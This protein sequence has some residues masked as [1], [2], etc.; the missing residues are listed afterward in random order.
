MS[1]TSKSSKMLL[2]ALGEEEARRQHVPADRLAALCLW[3]RQEI[4]PGVV[5]ARGAGRNGRDSLER[6]GCAERRS[7]SRVQER[8]RAV[9]EL[10]VQLSESS[11]NQLVALPLFRLTHHHERVP[12]L[13]IVHSG[14]SRG[15]NAPGSQSEEPEAGDEEEHGRRQGSD[16]V[17]GVRKEVGEHALEEDAEVGANSVREDCVDGLVAR[18]GL[19]SLEGDLVVELHREADV[20]P[21]DGEVRE[22]IREPRHDAPLRPLAGIDHCVK[23]THGQ[24][25]EEE[26]TL[27][28]LDESGRVEEEKEGREHVDE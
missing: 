8:D 9:L 7:R 22:V 24:D 15:V 27:Q 26:V 28:A 18:F 13:E 16:F 11:V 19:G 20:R 17:G 5:R 6:V 2:A 1:K 21:H 3:E 25:E 23:K 14:G 12:F 4:R 10:A